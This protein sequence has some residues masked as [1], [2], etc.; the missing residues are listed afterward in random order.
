MIMGLLLGVGLGVGL[1]L[2]GRALVPRRVPLAL[3]LAE[4]ER[5]RWPQERT[6]VGLDQR[7]AG[8]AVAS[9]RGLGV[10]LGRAACD[11]R[12]TGQTVEAHAVEKLTAAIAGFVTP[13]ALATVAIVGGVTVPYGVVL[14]A[15]IGFGIAGFSLP[16]IILRDRARTRRAAFRTALSAYLDLVNVLLAG[17]AGM[18]TALQAAAEAGDGWAF[19]EIRRALEQAR[20]LRTSPWDAF[21]ALGIELGVIELQE[22]AASVRLAGEQGAKIK[23]SLASKATALRVQ[24]LARTEAAAHAASERMAI[25]NVAMFLGFLIF[26]GYPALISIVGGI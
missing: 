9:L 23:A 19:A 26:A 17:A 2:I 24:Q 20:V 1:C 25:P 18:E 11:R 8:R 4:L 5:P 10:D 13:V 15:A 16:D 21:D 22:L 7:L 12:V 6:N 3:A 14:A